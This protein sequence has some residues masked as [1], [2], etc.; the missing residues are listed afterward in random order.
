MSQKAPAEMIHSILS[1]FKLFL[2]FYDPSLSPVIEFVFQ[3]VC[4]GIPGAG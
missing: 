1:H 4:C 2:Q 3:F